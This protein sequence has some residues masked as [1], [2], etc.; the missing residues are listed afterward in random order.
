MESKSIMEQERSLEST[1]EHQEKRK[2]LPLYRRLAFGT[3]NFINVLAVS[4]WF[5]YNV[6]F[7]QK[8]IQLPPKSA[9]T[10][11]L[12]AQVGGA[13]STPFIGLW[14]DL[15]VCRV[16]GRRKIFQ[17]IGILSLSCSFFFIWHDC[18]GCQGVSDP[19]KVLYYSCFAIVFEFGWAATQ[20]GQLSLIPELT[21]SKSIQVELNT[22]R[23]SAQLTLSNCYIYSQFFFTFTCRYAFAIV[24]NLT[25]FSI[26]W[27]LL[28]K[29][30]SS[31]DVADLT[32]DDKLIFWVSRHSYNIHF[33][34]VNTC[35]KD[36]QVWCVL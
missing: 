33:S 15:C 29:F 34:I 32:P 26:F 35:T 22:I 25:V 28:E 23:Y 4:M 19:Y 30:N 20:V 2:S 14:S 21:V 18:L 16:P 27:G 12:V 36:V 3:G 1:V 17:L 5:P 11:V 9:G 10:I 8:V 13:V 6:S 7:F 24:A 31:V